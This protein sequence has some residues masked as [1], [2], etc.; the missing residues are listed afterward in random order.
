MKIQVYLRPSGHRVT[1][2]VTNIYPDDER[3]FIYNGVALSAEYSGRDYLGY[4]V[5]ADY[6]AQTEDGEPIESIELSRG[7]S[8][9]DTLH[10]LR[11]KVERALCREHS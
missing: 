5:Y 9:E 10:T 8:C 4:V 2:T 11:L 1:V 7:R 6:G 3:F